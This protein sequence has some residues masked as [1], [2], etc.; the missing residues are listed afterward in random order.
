MRLFTGQWLKLWSIVFV[1]LLWSVAALI[2]DLG[3]S[4][5]SVA[6]V[7]PELV[8][9]LEGGE[10]FESILLT[11]QRAASG[12]LL[13]FVI[14]TAY[15]ILSYVSASFNA[16]TRGLHSVSMYVPSLIVI[17]LGVN[18]LGR[19]L[20]S[21]ACI[22]AICV[23]AE[24]GVYMRDGLRNFDPEIRDMARSYKVRLAPRLFGMYLPF[25]IPSGLAASRIGFTLALKV[26]FLC[27]VFG[28]PKG[29]GWEVRSSFQYYDMPLLLAWLVLFIALLLVAEQLVRLTEKVV[30]KW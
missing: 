18:A 29:L 9:I 26:T 2:I 20:V 3:D 25:L 17:F 4:F 23:F 13:A 24:I 7:V 28:T 10:A 27:E 8:G 21:V 1:L 30:V 22:I 15:G 14:G 11:F 12:F 19:D 16:Y 5:P 6:R